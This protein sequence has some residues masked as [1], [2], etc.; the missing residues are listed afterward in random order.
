MTPVCLLTVSQVTPKLAALRHTSIPLPADDL[1]LP[2]LPPISCSKA[3]APLSA[4]TTTTSSS[5]SSS[6]SYAATQ[7]WL[8]IEAF[9]PTAL[10][11]AT[12]TRPKRIRLLASDGSLHDFLL[13]GRDDLRMDER[14]MQ[15]LRTVNCL[16]EA[17]AKGSAPPLEAAAANM[18][19]AV[20]SSR[21]QAGVSDKAAEQGPHAVAAAFLARTGGK[22]AVSSGIFS[23]AYS[24]HAGLSVRPYSVTPLGPRAGVVQW[25]KK[26]VSLFGIFRAWQQ[27]MKERHAAVM[28]ASRQTQAQAAAAAAAAGARGQGGGA[29]GQKGGEGSA[30]AAGQGMGKKQQLPLMVAARRPADAFYARLLPALQHAGLPAGV[31]RTKWPSGK[32]LKQTY[33]HKDILFYLQSHSVDM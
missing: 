16:L 3:I 25:V 33:C 15:I 26:T 9:G 10:A 24:Q 1:N 23:G 20:S 19:A 13:K 32:F 17:Q 8:T 27:S 5:S 11:L 30:E 18:G 29:G 31:A 7:S 12:K 14:I 21:P 22:A 28:A 4:T 2:M 6:M